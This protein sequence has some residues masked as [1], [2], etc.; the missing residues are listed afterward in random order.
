VSVER[1]S[2]YLG[3]NIPSDSP[4]RRARTDDA[5]TWTEEST[6]FVIPDFE[7]ELIAQLSDTLDQHYN[8]EAGVPNDIVRDAVQPLQ[9]RLTASLLE[10]EGVVDFV[11][12][13]MIIRHPDLDAQAL[14]RFSHDDVIDALTEVFRD[15]KYWPQAHMINNKVGSQLSESWPHVDSYGLG[16]G[17]L[18]GLISP[19]V[20]TALHPGLGNFTVDHRT[21]DSLTPQTQY[22]VGPVVAEDGTELTQRVQP[23]PGSLILMR[24]SSTVHDFPVAQGQPL[25][26]HGIV[27]HLYNPRWDFDDIVSDV[28]QVLYAA[29]PETDLASAVKDRIT[30]RIAARNAPPQQ[31]LILG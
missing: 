14:A 2:G 7:P 5:Q 6:A 22:Y 31:G 19:E 4:L 30:Q 25:E 24:E 29:T 11:V 28:N 10:H 21:V 20:S 3:P 17:S 23:H 26:G 1:V 16:H 13:E 18:S 9:E 27:R 15:E 8:H 12:H